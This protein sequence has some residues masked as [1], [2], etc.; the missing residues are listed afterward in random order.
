MYKTGS[1]TS[2]YASHPLDRYFRD[3]HTAAQHFVV[4]TKIAECAGRVLVGI[5]PDVQVSRFTTSQSLSVIGELGQQ[6]RQARRLA[7]RHVPADGIG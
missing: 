6:P 3:I 2:L 4:S 5:K 1:G 7:L